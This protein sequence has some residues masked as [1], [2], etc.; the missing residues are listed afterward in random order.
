[1]ELNTDKEQMLGIYPSLPKHL[2][3]IADDEPLMPE[4]LAELMGVSVRS[5][6]R[7]CE[8]GKIRAF[9]YNRKYVVYGSDFK[10]FML[11]SFVR[12]TNVRDMLQ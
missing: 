11:Q 5:V 7:Y 10:D 4:D 8:S 6:R 3:N 1:M 9:N 12:P 2:A